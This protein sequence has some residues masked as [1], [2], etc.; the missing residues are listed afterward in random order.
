MPWPSPMQGTTKWCKRMHIWSMK[1]I[2]CEGHYCQEMR[3]I[4]IH[5][6]TMNVALICVCMQTQLDCYT[7]CMYKDHC[8]CTHVSACVWVRVCVL[9]VG[10]SVCVCL[11]VEVRIMFYT[12]SM[13]IYI[14]AYLCV[15][16]VE[17]THIH[18]SH[19]YWWVCLCKCS[20]PSPIVDKYIYTYI[21]IMLQPMT[22]NRCVYLCMHVCLYIHMYTCMCIKASVFKHVTL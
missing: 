10:I 8:A 6:H 12:I 16:G 22:N 14:Y 19:V 1:T 3:N 20:S 5:L 2:V 15:Q 13:Y 18:T 7:C 21:Y 9:C 17:L 11:P 4:T